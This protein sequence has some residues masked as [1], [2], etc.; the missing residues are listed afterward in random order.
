MG[1]R[2]WFRSISI[3][4]VRTKVEGNL[5]WWPVSDTTIFSMLGHVL[6]YVLYAR[7]SSDLLSDL[8]QCSRTEGPVFLAIRETRQF[9]ISNGKKFAINLRSKAEGTLLGTNE[10][11]LKVLIL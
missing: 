3:N 11:D 6:S 7:S 5:A 9:S 8:H 10:S 2:E 1:R 4:E